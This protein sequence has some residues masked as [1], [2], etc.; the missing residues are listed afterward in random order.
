MLI[1]LEGCDGVGKTTLANTLKMC[2]NMKYMHCTADTPN[3]YKFFKDIIL[4]GVHEDIICD[5][6]FW[7][8]FVY[9]KPEERH[10]SKEE[11]LKLYNLFSIM[12]RRNKIILVEAPYDRVIRTLHYRKE[13]TV[14]PVTEIVLRFKE[15]ALES[16]N[17]IPVYS[18]NSGFGTMRRI[19]K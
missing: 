4:R 1:V 17:D 15:I 2:Y 7:G 16:C 18:Y 9:Q 14:L 13:Q 11:L 3:D 6:F 5:R 19:T 8:Q 10:L 12:N